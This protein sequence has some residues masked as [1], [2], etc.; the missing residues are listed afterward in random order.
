L[1]S[2]LKLKYSVNH[3]RVNYNNKTGR[4]ES[5]TESY[6][7]YDDARE[8]KWKCEKCLG[9]FATI[10]KLKQHKIDIHSY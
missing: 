6:A 5:G 9:R 1:K 4:Y 10:K 8:N 7:R 3:N 2:N